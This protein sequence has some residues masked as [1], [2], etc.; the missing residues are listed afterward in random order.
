MKHSGKTGIFL[1]GIWDDNIIILHLSVG[2]CL[3]HLPLFC[4]CPAC[5]LLY[6]RHVIQGFGIAFVDL[7]DL[8]KGT[9]CLIVIFP[10]HIQKSQ[11]K[12]GFYKMRL[13]CHHTGQLQDRQVITAVLCMPQR[14]V[15]CFHIL[16][17]CF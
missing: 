17:F 3:D 14:L 8:K 12:M 13:G 6:Q 7:Q 1:V 2:K 16:A 10:A 11:K 15:K 9:S 4:I 5:I